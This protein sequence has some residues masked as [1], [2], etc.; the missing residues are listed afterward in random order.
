FPGESELQAKIARKSYNHL[1]HL[2]LEILMIFGPMKKF[3]EKRVDLL[4]V[5]N[6]RAAEEKGKGVIFL[7]SHVGNWE[8]MAGTGTLLAHAELLLVTKR[9]KPG[10]LH[11]AIEA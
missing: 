10:W 7:S 8:I 9:I 3:I 2:V 11:K 1:G 6:L 5:E 4:G